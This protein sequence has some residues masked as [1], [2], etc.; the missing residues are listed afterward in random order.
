MFASLNSN[1]K[2]INKMKTIKFFLTAIALFFS[3]NSVSAHGDNPHLH[4]NPRWKE[5]SFQI[6]P[7]LTQ[8][9]WHQFAAEAGLVTYFRPLVDAKPMG[10]K[11]FEVSILQ[12]N[13]KIDEGDGAWNNTF[14]HPDST[15]W[16]I[17][18][19]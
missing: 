2:K 4:I 15:H 3:V 16:L 8:S 12:W 1:L 11:R 9:E 19:E 7:S 5:C 6:D 10:R 18:G 14:V 17:G 13:T